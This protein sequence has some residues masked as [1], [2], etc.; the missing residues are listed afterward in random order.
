MNGYKLNNPIRESFR[1][2]A[3]DRLTES[4]DLISRGTV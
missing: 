4:P 3:H 1:I 2:S